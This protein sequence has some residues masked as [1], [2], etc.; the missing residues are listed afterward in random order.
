[1]NKTMYIVSGL[2]GLGK[3]TLISS[4]ITHQFVAGPYNIVPVV[5]STDDFVQGAV[6][7]AAAGTTY[8]DMWKHTIKDAERFTNKLFDAA[9]L[10]GNPIIVDQTN[11]TSKKRATRIVPAIKNGY[12][13]VGIQCILPT[14]LKEFNEWEHRLNSRPG[15]NIPDA[16]LSN[17][18]NS[19]ELM[20]YD[21]GFSS[22]TDYNSFT[23]IFKLQTREQ[24]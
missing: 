14:T 18:A 9:L 22:I 8:N 13:V 6:E 3:S 21:E 24:Q 20:S 23:N 19:M 4:T 7:M 10:C 15:K 11:L 5:I 2:P 12:T 1:M 17:M 16:I